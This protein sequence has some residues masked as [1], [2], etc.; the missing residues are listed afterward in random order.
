MDMSD[1]PINDEW[2]RDGFHYPRPMHQH[3]LTRH[4]RLT[5]QDPTRQASSLDDA[6]IGIHILRL[7]NGAIHILSFYI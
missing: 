2:F 1:E 4:K 7:G 6:V 3:K 5:P